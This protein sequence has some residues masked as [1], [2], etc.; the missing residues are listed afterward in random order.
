MSY[1]TL[2][3]VPE[4]AWDAFVAA[5]P[6][7]HTLQTAAWGRFKAEFGWS[8]QLVAVTD[9]GGAIQAGALILYKR[10]HRLIPL[11]I[12][13]IPC[14][15]L[16]ADE[17]ANQMLWRALD[18]AARSHGAAWLKVEP[19]DWYRPRPELPELLQ[20]QGFRQS[21]QT[22]QPPRTIVIDLNGSED[23][24]LKRM[25][26]S[27]RRKAKMG[28]K[29][30]VD[31][32]FGTAADVVSFTNLMAVT[33]T[34]DKFGVHEPAYYQRAFELFAPGEHCALVLAS[35]AGV[36]LAGV[37]A[38][39]CGDKAYYLYGA[40]SNEERN[41]MPT[42]IA[43]WAAIRW[44]HERGAKYYDFWGIPDA[45]EAQLEAEFEQ[46]RDG[47]WGVYGFKR[48]WG[49]Q[50]VRSVGAW[51]KVYL[52]PVYALYQRLAGRGQAD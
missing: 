5:H 25:N 11:S 39:R 23:D 36:D 51:D 15:P 1:K 24:L 40:S 3:T 27:T 48:G 34:R 7:A 30:E 47:L 43:Q 41:R 45:P 50:I 46:R 16:L 2:F 20:K 31:V 9:D 26:Q 12:G 49:G 28:A 35:H 21:V 18:Q 19:C 4:A 17:A 22:V 42:Y 8:S 13:Y 33:G 6:D 10:A 37:M 14:G 29:M 52:P 32:R 38:F 44:A